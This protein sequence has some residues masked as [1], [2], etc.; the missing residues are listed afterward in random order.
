MDGVFRHTLRPLTLPTSQQVSKS[1]GISLR[2]NGSTL[3]LPSQRPRIHAL[4]A[5]KEVVPSSFNC[6]DFFQIFFTRSTVTAV[7]IVRRKQNPSKA[8]SRP[9]SPYCVTG[10]MAM[11]NAES[12]RHLTM[13]DG[14][15]PRCGFDAEAVKAWMMATL[16]A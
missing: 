8:N 5:W 3:C 9:I 6:D 7:V 16:G 12:R 13:F 2:E 11:A 15:L 4:M 14:R 10:L 1:S